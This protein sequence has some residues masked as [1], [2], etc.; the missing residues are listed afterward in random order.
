M[1]C[2]RV[3][4]CRD[5]AGQERYQALAP[6]YYRGAHGAV[7]VYDVT[8][9]DSLDKAQHWMGELRRFAGSAIGGQEPRHSPCPLSRRGN[10]HT[11]AC[12]NPLACNDPQLRCSTHRSLHMRCWHAMTPDGGSDPA[13]KIATKS[14]P[15][16]SPAA[17][18]LVA[19]KTDLAGQRQVTEQ[20][21]QD[22]AD[23][24]GVQAHSQSLS[25]QNMLSY[26][27]C[28]QPELTCVP[29]RTIL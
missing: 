1:P 22:T 23:R 11:L 7:V 26:S 6:L 14:F 9:R 28:D 15:P 21:G 8:Q 18:V 16:P 17:L 25:S 24:Y 5:T 13:W 29:V 4:V 2:G 27:S 12:S 3:L 10:R 19:N 20:E